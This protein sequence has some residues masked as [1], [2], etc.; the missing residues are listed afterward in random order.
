M[1]DSKISTGISNI[2]CVLIDR[3]TAIITRKLNFDL[4]VESGFSFP[5]IIHLTTVM[6]LIKSLELIIR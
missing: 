1:V 4:Y 6:N 5:C 2:M 3:E